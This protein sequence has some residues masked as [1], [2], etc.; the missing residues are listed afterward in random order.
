MIVTHNHGALLIASNYWGSDLDRTGKFYCSVNAGAVRLLL[1]CSRYSLVGEWR[2][3]EYV[4][5]SRGPWPEQ[6][7][8][9]AVEILFEDH[10]DSPYALH[11]A[12]QSFD[13]L[14]VE[15]EIGREWILSVWIEKK[16][17]PHKALERACRWRRSA[18]LPDLSKWSDTT[19]EHPA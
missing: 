16:A 17:R 3:C 6:G 15:P 5:L 1:P 13:L 19:S 10:S 4:I 7:L 9:E 14:P 12:G 2:S 11:L 18:F 8:D